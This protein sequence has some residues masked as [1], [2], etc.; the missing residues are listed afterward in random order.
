MPHLSTFET[1]DP[2]TQRTVS[3]NVP[4]DQ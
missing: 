1:P 4:A 2:T 3:L